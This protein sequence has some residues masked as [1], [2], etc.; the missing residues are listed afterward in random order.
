M[1]NKRFE[2]FVSLCWSSDAMLT[3][4]HPAIS[5]ER[6]RERFMAYDCAFA[7]LCLR[8]R[9]PTRGM[10]AREAELFANHPKPGTPR[11]PR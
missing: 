3:D 8:D 4:F 5:A 6:L 2:S 7:L 11:I 9:T 10:Y 1:D